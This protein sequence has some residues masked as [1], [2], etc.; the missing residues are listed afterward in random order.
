MGNPALLDHSKWN[1]ENV[2]CRILHL[3]D[4]HFSEKNLDNAFETL[5]LGKRPLNANIEESAIP[6]M[7]HDYGLRG[8]IKNN[9]VDCIVITGDFTDKG[10]FSKK[11]IQYIESKI[12]DLYR[13]C[14]RAGDWE[15]NGKLWYNDESLPMNRLFYCAGNHDLLR[16]AFAY[17]E[18][19]G[20][21]ISRQDVVKKLAEQQESD[22]SGYLNLEKTDLK[23]LTASSFG[24]FYQMVESLRRGSEVTPKD[25]NYEGAFFQLDARDDD[26]DICFAAI[27]TALLAGSTDSA[28]QKTIQDNWLVLQTSVDVQEKCKAAEEYC[29]QLQK[30]AGRKVDDAG[31]L[32]MPSVDALNALKKEFDRSSRRI[33]IMLGHHNCTSFCDKAKAA[34]SGFVNACGI[35][36]YLCGHTHR[37]DSKSIATYSLYSK[38]KG[39]H[40]RVSSGAFFNKNDYY[41][42]LGFSIHTILRQENDSYSCKS[43]DIVYSRLLEEWMWID[44]V[45]QTGKDGFPLVVTTIVNSITGDVVPPPEEPGDGNPFEGGGE[46]RKNVKNECLVGSQSS[47]ETSDSKNLSDYY[48]KTGQLPEGKLI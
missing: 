13:I 44:A 28:D 48:K 11:N 30:Q 6:Q 5:C 19:D 41:S 32:L 12:K 16:D 15:Y 18:K 14:A 23:L 9:P 40:I 22:K 24:P 37:P 2:Y 47:E 38:E 43:A 33:G 8:Y 21:Y 3:S 36:L 46:D 35:T 25:Y 7:L 10:D 42:T 17:N 31:K 39:L 1:E 34:F 45:P 26:P 29:K 27:N 20:K 4:L